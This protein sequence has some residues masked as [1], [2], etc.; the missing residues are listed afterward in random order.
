M[1][2]L[3]NLLN[4]EE[5]NNFLNNNCLTFAELQEA[6]IEANIE[7]NL[8]WDHIIKYPKDE[9]FGDILHFDDAEDLLN[10]AFYGNYK[11]LHEFIGFDGNGN[12]ESMDKQ[13]YYAELLRFQDEILKDL[14]Q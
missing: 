13:E 4:N 5:L 12:I 3:K 9:F 14:E 11:P 1:K 2:E 7:S 8:A 10:M 6:I